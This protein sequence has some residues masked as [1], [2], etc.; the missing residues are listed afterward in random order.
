MQLALLAAGA[1]L[2]VMAGL[3]AA[4]R[5]DTVRLDRRLRSLAGNSVWLT[6]DQHHLAAS[7]QMTQFLANRV[8][9]SVSG[10]SFAAALQ[11][12]LLRADVKL[13]VGEFLILQGVAATIIGS[14]AFLIAGA[15]VVALVFAG[16]GWLVP[17]YWLR[18]RHAARLKTFNDQLAD[19]LSLMSN[20][21][22]SGLS[23][24]QSME[25]MAREA[26]PPTSDEF[27]RVVREIALGVRPQE[28]LQH[29][30]QRLASQDF[31]LVVTAILVQF[32]VGGNLS[33]VLDS[34]AATIRERVKL[35]GEIKTL[36]AQ[37]KMAGSM[38]S[39]LPIVIAG[40]LMLIAPSYIGKLFTPGPWLALPFVAGIGLVMGTVV[41]RKL[42]NIDI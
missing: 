7:A 20:S 1:V 8:N 18:R 23:L 25:T 24:V 9:R 15:P 12:A 28:A 34:I 40:V 4:F 3:A 14:L 29:C 42:T 41:M 22:R 17:R 32:D 39:G 27:N 35:H 21:L 31:D 36:S 11:L 6:D 38:L 19:A 33:K 16:L 26:A 37:G 10:W 13:T 30:N 2:A 5:P